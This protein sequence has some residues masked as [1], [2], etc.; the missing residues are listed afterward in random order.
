MNT[1]GINPTVIGWDPN[2]PVPKDLV[3]QLLGPDLPE[4]ELEAADSNSLPGLLA[5]G[6]SKSDTGISLNYYND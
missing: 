4:S 2:T 3:D 1:I 6:S 5:P